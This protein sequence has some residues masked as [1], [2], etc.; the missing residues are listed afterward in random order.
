MATGV[1]VVPAV[2]DERDVR[3][4]PRRQDMLGGFDAAHIK[5]G[6]GVELLNGE[7]SVISHHGEEGARPGVSG[8]SPSGF[9]TL[10]LPA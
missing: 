1:F 6:P 10:P 9:K 2:R 8:R 4:G 7:L 5:A 3:L